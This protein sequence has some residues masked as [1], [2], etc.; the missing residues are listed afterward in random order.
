MELTKEAILAGEVNPEEIKI[1]DLR[2][3]VKAE[4]LECPIK[5]GTTMPEGLNMIC[6][7]LDIPATDTEQ[8]SG[9]T[10]NEQPAKPAEV[11]ETGYLARRA[12]RI[13]ADKRATYSAGDGNNSID[14]DAYVGEDTPEFIK[15]RMRNGGE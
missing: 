15:R 4:G 7:A 5:N 10:T 6:D 2:E 11:T 8:D 14:P 1:A 12:S 3:F 9:P 13:T